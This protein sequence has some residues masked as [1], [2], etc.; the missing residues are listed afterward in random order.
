MTPGY[1]RSL[2]VPLLRGRAFRGSDR[3]DAPRVVIVN[4]TLAERYWP[5]ANPVGARVSPEWADGEWFTVVGVVGDVR[6]NGLA[7]EAVPEIYFP[8]AQLAGSARSMVVAVE[9]D[10]DPTRFAGGL[11][12]TVWALDPEL[13]IDRLAP[14][15]DIVS[16]SVAMPRLHLWTFGVFAG[17]AL[18]LAAVGLYGVTSTVVAQRTREIGIRMATGARPMDVMRWVLRWVAVHAAVGVAIGLAGGL[19]L[20]RMLQGLLHG[21]GPTDPATFAAVAATLVAATLLAGMIPARRAAAVDPMVALRV[22]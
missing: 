9:T 11:R 13:P 18:L 16:R 17:L 3:T 7:R 20:S 8:H 14:M 19:L 21:P 22:D 15:H 10:G 12:R 5:E 1:F 2:G 6:H 4:A